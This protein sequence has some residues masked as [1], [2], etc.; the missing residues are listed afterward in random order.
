VYNS[1]IVAS[2]DNSLLS[3]CDD[4]LEAPALAITSML[5]DNMGWLIP[6]IKSAM[7]IILSNRPNFFFITATFSRV[8]S[9]G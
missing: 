3:N 8:N 7:A 1:L 6:G 2:N 5:R 4:K 9:F